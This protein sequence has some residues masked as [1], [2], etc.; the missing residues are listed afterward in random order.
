MS[1]GAP[2]FIL[3]LGVDYRASVALLEATLSEQFFP[4]RPEGAGVPALLVRLALPTFMRRS[5]RHLVPAIHFTGKYPL[6]IAL[7]MKMLACFLPLE[8][9]NLLL[10]RKIDQRRLRRHDVGW[11]RAPE[12]RLWCTCCRHMTG[13]RVDTSVR[14]RK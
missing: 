2:S 13:C 1:H 3:S 9:L 6:D 11:M 4:P 7:M 10:G 5:H 12:A 8:Q 14:R